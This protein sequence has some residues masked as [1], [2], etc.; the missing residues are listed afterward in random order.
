MAH[1]KENT[2]QIDGDDLIEHIL[3]IVLDRNNFAF[4]AR[5][6]EKAVDSPIGVEAGLHI[7]LNRS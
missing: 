4:D 7:V 3:I 1:P 6:V 5:V 2:F